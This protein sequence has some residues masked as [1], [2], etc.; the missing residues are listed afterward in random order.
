MIETTP[1]PV[2]RSLMHNFYVISDIDECAKPR[3]ICP[4]LTECINTVGSYICDCKEAGFKADGKQCLGK[5]SIWKMLKQHHILHVVIG[6]D[7]LYEHC[8]GSLNGRQIFFYESKGCETSLPEK[9]RKYF[10]WGFDKSGFHCICADYVTAVT[11]RG[12]NRR[13]AL[14]YC[15]V[16]YMS[17]VFVKKA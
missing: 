10:P 12:R 7:S 6:P 11:N 8:F 15:L 17:V 3:D 1:T 13:L 2:Q 16:V 14:L 4:Y 5:P 9:T